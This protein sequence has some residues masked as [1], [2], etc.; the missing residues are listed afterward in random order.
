MP[1]VQHSLETHCHPKK[2]GLK[3]K[4]SG[5]I[6]PSCSTQGDVKTKRLKFPPSLT[7]CC[8]LT[9]LLQHSCVKENEPNDKVQ[10]KS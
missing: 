8:S 6:W 9:F 2:I 5:N 4:H 1:C 3:T 7:S 10:Q